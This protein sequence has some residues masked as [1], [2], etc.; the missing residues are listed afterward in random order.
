MAAIDQPPA[1]AC[2]VVREQSGGRMQICGRLVS[3][4]D[5]SG[6]YSLQIKKAGPSGSSSVS[7]GGPFAAS[8]EQELFVGN[9]TFNSDPE[10]KFVVE[11][12]IRVGDHTVSCEP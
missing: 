3:R 2:S 10:T 8:A 1:I 11:F 7:Q 12:S 6:I 5:V 4:A 9:A